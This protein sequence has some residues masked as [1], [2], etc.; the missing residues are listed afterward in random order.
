MKILLLTICIHTTILCNG[1]IDRKIYGPYKI[2]ADSIVSLYVGQDTF[3]KYIKLDS[4][5]SEFL[6]L[7]N[8]WDNKTKFNESLDFNPNVFEFNYS[9]NHPALL[10][11]SFNI[12][13]M[14]FVVS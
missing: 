9:V 4:G 1:Q 7:K 14:S 10:G 6:V 11:E 12:S 2:K 8:H 13:F 3:D 5:Q